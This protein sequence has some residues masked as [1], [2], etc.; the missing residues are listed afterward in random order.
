MGLG[1][2][3]EAIAALRVRFQAGD[4][5]GALIVAPAGLL[6]QWR[7]ELRSWAPEL[8]VATARGTPSERRAAWLAHANVVLVSYEG[9]VADLALTC[10]GGPRQRHW[11]VVIADEAQRIKNTN[12]DAHA[13]VCGLP[14]SSSW[15]LTG[16]PLENR[17]DDL[18]AILA[19]VAPGRF[20]RRSMMIGLRKLLDEMLLRRRRADV[21]RDLPPKIRFQLSPPL[22][23]RQRS[24]YCAA[25]REGIVW[26]RSLGA[27][28]K[29]T[30]VLELILRLKQICN[31]HPETG[32]SAKLDDL[33]V[34]L[35]AL[36]SAGEKSLVFSQFVQAPFG[37]MAAAE[38]LRR[39][40][41]LL[42]TGGQDQAIRAQAI[43]QFLNDSDR[44]VLLLS[45]RAGGV[46]LNLTGA[47]VVFLL[48][49][50]WTPAAAAQAE[51]RAHRM[52]Q[53]KPVQVFSYLTPDT[54]ES[55]I[56]GI[57]A[58]KQAL[59]DM[60][61]EGIDTVDLSRLGLSGLLEAVGV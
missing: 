21:L 9:L 11:G 59:F 7:S 40:R 51:D 36:A 12:T 60:F 50:W 41:P 37:V 46:G 56:A 32:E 33:A 23:P 55:R 14:R 39:L 58:R 35:G 34:R 27:A 45:L 54:I 10:P 38:R 49:Q 20:D 5:G 25:E 29:V 24:A 53:T 2:T 43:S 28:V 48:D 13:A 42:V 6:L 44:R 47:S 3:I 17:L 22:L 1:K 52:G 4:G 31:A 8:S 57:I 18:I 19:F 15:A 61:V 30:H 16:T 26:L